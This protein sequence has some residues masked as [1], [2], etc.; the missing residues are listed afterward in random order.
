MAFSDKSVFKRIGITVN[1]ANP[2][3]IR[4]FFKALKALPQLDPLHIDSND[5]AFIQ[6]DDHLVEEPL[7][8]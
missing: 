3:D 8:K 1:H 7:R 6:G 5:E 4:R 2:L